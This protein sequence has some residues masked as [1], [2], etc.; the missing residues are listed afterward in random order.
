MKDDKNFKIVSLDNDIKDDTKIIRFIKEEETLKKTLGNFNAA[1]HL[2]YTLPINL[3]SYYRKCEGLQKDE[4]EGS[5]LI[6]LPTGA[7]GKS[8]T[9]NEALISCW[10]I[11]KEGDSEDNPWLSFPNNKIAQSCHYAIVTTVGNFKQQIQHIYDLSKDIISQEILFQNLICGR[12]NYYSNDGLPKQVWDQRTDIS[13]GVDITCIQNIFHKPDQY[14][15]EQEFRFALIQN[16][17]RYCVGKDKKFYIDT[18]DFLNYMIYHPLISEKKS[19]YILKVYNRPWKLNQ[20]ISA[21]CHDANIQL[22]L[23][24]AIS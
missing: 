1:N 6:C 11:L 21:T 10:S 5:T 24:N 7:K 20:E 8:S 17:E 22:A 4:N 2:R 13:Q 15:P 23:I 9:C 3:L 14:E 16:G 18:K 12:I 19:H